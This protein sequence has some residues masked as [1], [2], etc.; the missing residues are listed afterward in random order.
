MGLRYN[1]NKIYY[2]EMETKKGGEEPPFK[3][4]MIS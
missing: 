1:S 3:L 4:R 2:I